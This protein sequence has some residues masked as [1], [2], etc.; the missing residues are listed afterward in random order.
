MLTIQYF[1][2]YIHLGIFPSVGSFFFWNS[3]IREIDA[4]RCGIYM[5]LIT[6]FTAIISV[7]LG[8]PIGLS[9]IV[10]GLFVFAV[11]Y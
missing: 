2:R 1:K 8:K 9:Q 6:V 3:T 7:M 4:S 5:N 10:G 11:V